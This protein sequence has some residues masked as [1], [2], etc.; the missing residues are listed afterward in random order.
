METNEPNGTSEPNG[1]QIDLLG[2]RKREIACAI[3]AFSGF[4]AACYCSSIVKEK[5]AETNAATSKPAAVVVSAAQQG[6]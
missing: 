5:T 1:R 4:L 6:R 3:L 2:T